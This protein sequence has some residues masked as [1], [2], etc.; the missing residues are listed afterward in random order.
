MPR[1]IR[2]RI[3]C[4]LIGLAIA[5]FVVAPA[6]AV[7][8]SGPRLAFV[9]WVLKEPM[10][11]ALSSIGSNGKVRRDLIRG[12]VEPMPFD[13][14]SW[15]PDGS[16]L[17]FAGS[18]SLPPGASEDVDVK[19]PK[20]GIYVVA[21]EGGVPRVIPGTVGASHP[22]M[23]PDATR[24]A[25]SRSREHFHF[26]PKDPI[27]SL[28]HS[29]HSTSTWI[30]G[31]DGSGQHRLT[32]WRRGIEVIPSSFSP[33]GRLLALTRY[34]APRSP[35]AIAIELTSG[36]TR[37]LANEAVE[38]AYSPDGSRIAFVSYRDHI[39][40]EVDNDGDGPRAKSELYT[41]NANGSHLRR[42]THTVDWQEET[43]NW[44]PS[45]QRLAFTRTTGPE[46]LSFGLTNVIVEA[47]AN[48]SCP[49]IVYGKKR[50]NR[51]GSSEGPGIYA[52]AWQPGPGR[53]AGPLSC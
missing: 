21:A 2:R 42:V 27:G 3:S 41:M 6:E 39:G 12:A 46:I 14:G 20:A 47:N 23:S 29:Y 30:I 13:G 16:M 25:F 24:I 36:A 51:L 10:H 11:T 26:D 7:T 38:P 22:V 15:S 50:G 9:E 45:G 5:G 33:D 40:S 17:A 8:P 34:R 52:P 19:Q 44:D 31:L 48:G 35:Q 28:T 53:E 1:V 32:P 49:R 43:P 4:V 18:P 37:V